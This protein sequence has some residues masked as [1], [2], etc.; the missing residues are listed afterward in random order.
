LFSPIRVT[1]FAPLIIELKISNISQNQYLLH[2][3]SVCSQYC[4][5]TTLQ[6]VQ[7]T[8]YPDWSSVSAGASGRL[9][10]I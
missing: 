9:C 8:H 5:C 7:S 2:C 1:L 10:L 3:Q 4:T 6:Y